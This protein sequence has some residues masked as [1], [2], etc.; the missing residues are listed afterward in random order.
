MRD[1]FP[2]T[3]KEKIMEFKF[4]DV[5][6]KVYNKT[7]VLDKDV[8]IKIKPYLT[9]AEINEIT[10]YCLNEDMGA[11]SEYTYII[12]KIIDFCT[13]IDATE[14]NEDGKDVIYSD[15]VY[16]TIVSTSLNTKNDIIEILKTAIVNY[17]DI[18]KVINE[19][20]STYFVLKSFVNNINNSISKFDISKIQSGFEKLGETLKNNGNGSNK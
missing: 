3:Y 16:D 11:L 17:S 7:I 6:E 10:Q 2:R 5:D 9:Y 19:S 20:R 18:E 15:L 12:S 8:K 14:K 1:K 13:N 4:K